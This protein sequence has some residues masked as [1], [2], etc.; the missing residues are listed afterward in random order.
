[1]IVYNAKIKNDVIT[2]IS[3]TLAFFSV[4]G[5]PDICMTGSCKK[6]KKVVP[7]VASLSAL[8]LTILASLG[9]WL[10]KRQKGTP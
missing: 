9:F 10:F 6:K 5:N 3:K 1:M 8:I 4:D 7:L 2:N